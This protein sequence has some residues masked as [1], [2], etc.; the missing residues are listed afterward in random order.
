MTHPDIHGPI[1]QRAR[2]IMQQDPKLDFVSAVS[3]IWTNNLQQ[4]K[5]IS[6]GNDVKV[7]DYEF[8]ASPPICE[9]GMFLAGI[10]E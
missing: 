4:G 8:W 10:Q 6:V 2:Q 9:D 1:N 7:F 5:M 3:K